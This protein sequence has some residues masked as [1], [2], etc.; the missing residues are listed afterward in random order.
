MAMNLSLMEIIQ[1]FLIICVGDRDVNKPLSVR[2]ETMC[3][4]AYIRC[5][6]RIYLIFYMILFDN[7]TIIL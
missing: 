1:I 6:Y 4:D 2:H 5:S 3:L 7:T